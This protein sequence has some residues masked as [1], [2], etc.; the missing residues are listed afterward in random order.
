MKLTID[1]HAHIF[2]AKDIPLKGYL[3]SRKYEEKIINRLSAILS[4]VIARCIRKRSGK[5]KFPSNITYPLIMKLLGLI[6]GQQYLQWSNTLSRD[7]NK[8]TCEM[9]EKFQNDYIDLFIPLMIDYEYWFINSPDNLIKDQINTIYKNII[10]PYRGLVHPF[11]AFDPARELAYRKRLCNPDGELEKYGSLNLVKDAIENKGFIGVKL[12]NSLGYRPYNNATVDENRRKIPLHKKKY[13][14]HGAEYDQVLGELYEYCIE[15]EVPITTH[16]C[17][18]G[19]ESYPDASF[20][21]G[22]AVYWRKVLDQEKYNNLRI[23]LAHFGWYIEEGYRGEI[24]WV[25][26]I[27]KMLNDYQFLYADVA[28]HR[29]VLKKYYKQF[30]SDYNQICADYPIIKERLLFGTDWHVLKRVPNYPNF[31]KA[32]I[33][34]LS[35]N[36]NFSN[37][38][39]DNFLSG[40]ALNF[41]GLHKDDKNFQ[42]LDSFYRDHNI[43][44][45]G[46]FKTI[47]ANDNKNKEVTK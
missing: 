24:T 4:P 1:V 36:N 12:Y 10:L 20:D 17:M 25:E 9:F 15:R 43:N 29:V 18:Y 37:Q 7:I 13:L 42:R 16:C 21:F 28:C 39:I 3:L 32:Y 41:L 34:V 2:S 33:E 5:V 8:I 27:C 6:M 30:K 19:I 26:D 40:N 22:K 35:H 23:N 46:W 38:D 44:P 31:K 47:K 11:V 14:F 45:P